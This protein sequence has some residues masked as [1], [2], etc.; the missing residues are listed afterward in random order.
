MSYII[1]KLTI[2][3]RLILLSILPAK[4]S[5]IEMMHVKNLIDKL[6][7][8]D[9]ELEEYKIRQE[10]SFVTWD[11]DEEYYKEVQ[12]NSEEIEIL[13]KQIKQKDEAQEILFEM[14]ETF[15][16]IINN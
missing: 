8:D 10:N 1:K 13:K 5:L 16:K 15:N 12:F 3:D 6:S 4:G 2:K 11:N 7:F 9:K 14:I